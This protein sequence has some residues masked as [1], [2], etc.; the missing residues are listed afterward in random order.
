MSSA[1]KVSLNEETAEL[2]AERYPDGD[3]RNWYRDA[4][5]IDFGNAM[6]LRPP[7]HHVIT[8]LNRE[9]CAAYSHQKRCNETDGHL[10]GGGTIEDCPAE[11]FMN[12]IDGWLQFLAEPSQSLS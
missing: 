3:S 8:D 7:E 10:V 9:G 12:C 6:E 4:V 11:E 5:P 1:P 2:L